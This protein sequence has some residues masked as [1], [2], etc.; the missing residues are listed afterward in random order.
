M[1]DTAA[2]LTGAGPTTYVQSSGFGGACKT[3]FWWSD[4]RWQ[5]KHPSIY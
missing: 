1:H 4:N 5:E 2:K 3:I